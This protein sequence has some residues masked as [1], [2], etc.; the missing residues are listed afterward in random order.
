[1]AADLGKLPLHVKLG[2]ANAPRVRVLLNGNVVNDFIEVDILG[3]WGVRFARRPDGS[4]L[5]D[6]NLDGE[7]YWMT[8]KVHGFF[9]LQWVEDS[10]PDMDF[11]HYLWH[12]GF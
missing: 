12:G 9:A 4:P 11:S 6:K 1:M 3:C 5:Y 2:D 8:E 7:E 10:E